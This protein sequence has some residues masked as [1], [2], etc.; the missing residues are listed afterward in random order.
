[1][2]KS[3]ESHS[4][5]CRLV[6]SQVFHKKN[7]NI[8]GVAMGNMVHSIQNRII[9]VEAVPTPPLRSLTESQIDIIKTTWEIPAAKVRGFAHFSITY[10][11]RQSCIIN[12]ESIHPL[13]SML[14]DEYLQ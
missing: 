9:K 14:I 6:Q 3:S 12:S 10:D 1:V 13:L 4:Q 8:V 5:L 7:Y 2:D 11:N